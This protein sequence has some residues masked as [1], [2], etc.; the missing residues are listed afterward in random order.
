MLSRLLL[1]SSVAVQIVISM[2]IVEKVNRLPLTLDPQLEHHGVSLK[3]PSVSLHQDPRVLAQGSDEGAHRA[4]MYCL[5]LAA[6][7]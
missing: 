7:F 4:E 5:T 2:G 6:T 1:T 3:R